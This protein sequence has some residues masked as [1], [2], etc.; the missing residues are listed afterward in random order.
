MPY[1]SSG[2]IRIER[3]ALPQG[4]FRFKVS[5][6]DVAGGVSTRSFAFKVN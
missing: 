5:L 4:E 1:V 3:V 2:G 6:G